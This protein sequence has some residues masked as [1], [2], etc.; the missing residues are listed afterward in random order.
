[1]HWI[2]QENLFKESEW[3]NLVSVLER[4]NIPYSVHKVVPFIGELV[5]P[6][7]PKQDKVICM[8]SYSVRHSAKAN[9]W[10]PGVYDLMP[11]NFVEQMKAWGPHM[12]NADS[13]VVKF[14]NACVTDDTFIRP[15]DDSKYFAG[16]VFTATEFCEW[17]EKVCLLKEDHGTSLTEDTLIQLCQPKVIFAEYRFW[18]VNGKIVTQSLYKRGDRVAY[19]RDV[20]PRFDLFVRCRIQAWQPHQAFVIDVCDTPAGIKVVELNTL[21]AAGFY[22]ADVQKLLMALEELEDGRQL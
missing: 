9:G 1:M 6:A 3:E 21:N 19:S 18:V 10:N 13:Q 17:Q 16:K 7:E 14:K 8:G 20:D 2:L 5:P 11:M 4:F 12:L 15:V 22:A